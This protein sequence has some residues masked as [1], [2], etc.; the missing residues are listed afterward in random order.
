MLFLPLEDKD[1]QEVEEVKEKKKIREEEHFLLK[2]KGWPSEYNQQVPKSY[3]NAHAL[4]RKFEKTRK[5][6]LIT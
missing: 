1:D 4:I 3:I 2:Q 6:S 5:H